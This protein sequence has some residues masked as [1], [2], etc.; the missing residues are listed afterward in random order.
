MNR[1]QKT[2][3]GIFL[4]EQIRLAGMSQE[5]FYN[6]YGYSYNRVSGKVTYDH[7]EKITIPKENII[8]FV[9]RVGS[10]E[11][12]TDILLKIQSSETGGTL[13]IYTLFITIQKD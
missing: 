10:K 11:K 7:K 3:F 8:L 13:D 1:R 9:G 2:E 12:R 4:V 6:G 5:E